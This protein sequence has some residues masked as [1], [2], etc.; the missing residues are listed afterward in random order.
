[1]RRGQNKHGL[2]KIK[3]ALL[4]SQ[5]TI[6]LPVQAPEP[7]GSVCSS[8]EGFSFASGLLSR[9]VRFV[10]SLLYQVFRAPPNR[11]FVLFLI[12]VKPVVLFPVQ[13]FLGGVSTALFSLACLKQLPEPTC[14][15]CVLGPS[16][17]EE[18]VCDRGTVLSQ[19]LIRSCSP[20]RS[21]S[22][23]YKQL[24]GRRQVRTRIGCHLGD[25]GL[26]RPCSG[27]FSRP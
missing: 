3:H 11:R 27:G 23:D 20:S 10:V 25:P 19:N 17:F 16:R 12:G 24:I 9:P 1:V 14:S 21:D 4:S 7:V 2:K 22:F 6:T 8:A 18:D 26:G 5:E 15:E 13:R